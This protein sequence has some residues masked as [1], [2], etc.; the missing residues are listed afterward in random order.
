MNPLLSAARRFAED[1]GVS[2]LSTKTND[3][4]NTNTNTKTKTKTRTNTI[5]ST[6]SSSCTSNRRPITSSRSII[7]ISNRG[8]GPLCHSKRT[9]GALLLPKPPEVH[10]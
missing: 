8:P 5:T 4:T 1:G 6:N 9:C 2:P 7:S 10:K 3:N